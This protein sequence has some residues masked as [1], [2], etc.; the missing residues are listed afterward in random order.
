MLNRVFLSLAIGEFHFIELLNSVADYVFTFSLTIMKLKDKYVT[1]FN[2]CP[3]P[4]N[5]YFYVSTL[6]QASFSYF[7]LI[8]HSIRFIY[9][10]T[11][12]KLSELY[13]LG[14]NFPFPTASWIYLTWHN[15]TLGHRWLNPDLTWAKWVSFLWFGLGEE[16]S[17]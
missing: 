7:I 16:G 10:W 8:F 5:L 3:G 9:E 12:I 14:E 13:P 2:N 4:S 15:L 11:Y 17:K 1:P 6:T